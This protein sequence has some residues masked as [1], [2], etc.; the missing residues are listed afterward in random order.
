MTI[1]N[2]P[3]LSGFLHQQQ[4]PRL[5]LGGCLPFMPEPPESTQVRHRSA[6]QAIQ[7]PD[8]QHGLVTGG[9]ARIARRQVELRC[10]SKAAVRRAHLR[11]LA[12]NLLM[13]RGL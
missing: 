1:R 10:C 3:A 13:R 7:V 5:S 11:S 8:I 4:P 2:H 9:S 12:I 6:C